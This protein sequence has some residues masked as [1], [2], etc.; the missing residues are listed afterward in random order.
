MG[1]A[2]TAGSK[3][4]LSARRGRQQPTSLAKTTTSTRVKQTA[5]AIVILMRS[6]SISLIKLAD[7]SVMP[8]KAAT[9]ISFQMVLKISEKTISLRERPRM[10]E[11]L[12]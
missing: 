11:T 2:M 12:D 7:A 4:I 9:R 8:Q 3:P 5:S 10:T 1:E 6:K